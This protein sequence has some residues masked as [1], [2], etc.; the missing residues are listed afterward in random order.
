MKQ[1]IYPSET[2]SAVI[3]ALCLYKYVHVLHLHLLLL[4]QHCDLCGEGGTAP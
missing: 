2:Q 4:L 3:T 1:Q